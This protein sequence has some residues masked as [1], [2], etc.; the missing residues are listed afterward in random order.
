MFKIFCI[1][2][3]L[4]VL[5]F[6]LIVAVDLLAGIPLH[7]SL[8]SFYDVFSTTS[9]GVA[10]VMVFYVVLPLLI[11]IVKTLRRGSNHS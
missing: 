9:P 7:A 1:Y 11:R 5:T 3:L 4:A 2:V 10:I 8:H 6:I